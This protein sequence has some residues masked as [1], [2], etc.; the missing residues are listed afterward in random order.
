[1]RP[2]LGS[3]FVIKR[4]GAL[5]RVN[6]AS[7]ETLVIAPLPG[8]LRKGAFPRK[9]GLL[10]MPLD[11]AYAKKKDPISRPVTTPFQSAT[12]SPK[13]PIRPVPKAP[14]AGRSLQPF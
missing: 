13:E 1:M 7:G 5:Q 4:T 8:E 12:S 9:D 14:Q 6:P 11:P 3:V 10:G 2:S